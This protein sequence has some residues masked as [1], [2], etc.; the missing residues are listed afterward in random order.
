MSVE[1]TVE[2][3]LGPVLETINVDLVDVDYKG[4]NL[5]VV[6]NRV[7]GVD[8]ATL[9]QVNR[10][11]SPLLDQHDPIPGRYT[12]EVTSPGLERRLRRLKHYTDAIGE[13]VVIKLFPERDVR[14]LRGELTAVGE[15]WVT[16]TVT[17]IDGVEL[18][19]PESRDVVLAD[20]SSARTV[21][22]WGPQPKPGK[23]KK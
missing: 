9:V 8:T 10:L 20:I 14:R 22:E 7:D 2:Q 6:V 1:E 19:T 11:V 4:G 5:K 3:L 17:E 21:F 18:T 15:D 13:Q 12:L 23:A 16:V